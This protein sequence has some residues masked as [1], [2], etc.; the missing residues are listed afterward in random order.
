VRL[1]FFPI[2]VN[3][4]TG[5][6]LLDADLLRLMRS[7]RAT[8]WHVFRT[9]RLGSTGNGRNP[10]FNGR[11]Q[12]SR[13][14]TS[15]MTRECQVRFCERLGV[16]FPGPIRHF[17]PQTRQRRNPFR[18]RIA[19]KADAISTSWCIAISGREERRGYLEATA[20][21]DVDPTARP[22]AA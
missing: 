8:D 3:L 15:R 12:P 14:G 20:V 17:K 21:T 6:L 4:T 16:K 11:R 7:Y 13:G 9:V 2:V 22:S 5:L 1:A 10:M 18:G 19:R